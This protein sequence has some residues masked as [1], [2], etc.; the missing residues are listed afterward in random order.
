MSDRYIT[1]ER[2]GETVTVYVGEYDQVPNAVWVGD[3][4]TASRAARSLFDAARP[5]IK[6]IPLPS[7][8]PIG[9][10]RRAR[11]GLTAV[12][13]KS[14][15]E[16]EGAWRVIGVDPDDVSCHGWR[17]WRQ[18]HEWQVVGNVLEMGEAS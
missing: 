13:V 10:V 11:N 16:S 18:V 8:P 14:L 5:W 12:H 9:E 1:A 2:V 6:A 3:P 4:S 17:S 15:T 7:Q